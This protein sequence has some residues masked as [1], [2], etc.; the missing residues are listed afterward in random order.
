MTVE[1]CGITDPSG[2]AE[3]G[4]GSMPLCVDA[5]DV[6]GWGALWLPASSGM[7]YCRL[8]LGQ[9]IGETH[10]DLAEKTWDPPGRKRRPLTDKDLLKCDVCG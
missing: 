10:D 3:L 6:D 2:E 1:P 4:T 7:E 8:P 9:A 5:R